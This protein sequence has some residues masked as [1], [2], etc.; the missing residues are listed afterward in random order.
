MRMSRETNEI[1]R[2]R[3]LL[4]SL[5]GRAVKFARFLSLVIGLTAMATSLLT[6][7]SAAVRS[8][9][10][11]REGQAVVTR[12]TSFD[13]LAGSD[14]QYHEGAVAHGEQAAPDSVAWK[15]VT[16]PF[17]A[18]N[19]EVWIRRWV[20][21]PKSLNGYDLTGA[22]ISFYL[23]VGGD[24]PG[25]GYLYE[26][27]YGSG[28]LIAEGTH[29]Y[30]QVI[31]ADAHP[32][33][34]VLLAVKMP[35][36]LGE[37]RFDRVR[38]QVDFAEGRPDPDVMR[39]ELVSAATLLPLI[40]HDAAE[41]ASQEKTLDSAAR[42][43]NLDALDKG[44]QKAFDASLKDA[45]ARLEPLRPVMKKSFV[46]MTGNAHIDAAWLWS[47]T[48]T[49]DQVH[50]TFNNV[51]Q[52]MREYPQYAFS[53]SAAQY[54]EWMEQKFPFI[55]Q[56]IQQRVKEGRWELVGGMWV[57]PDLNLPDG[58]GEV[59]QILVGKQ[60]FQQK[61]GVDVK[62]GWNPDSFGYNWQ[63]PQIYKKSGIDYFL[64]QKLN[65]NDDNILPLKLFWWQSPDGSR[66]LTYFPHDY[67]QNIE[68][69]KMAHDLAAV[70]KANP[71]DDK[72]L[73]LYGGSLGRQGIPEGRDVQEAGILWS[74]PD[75]VYPDTRFT[76]AQAFFDDMA[77]RADTATTTVWNYKTL[78]AG[79][80]QVA[81]GADG[82]IHLPVWNDE[83]YLEHHR[84][85]YTTQAQEKANIRHS[86]EWL[87]DAEKYS[88]LAW[89][90][91]LDYPGNQ[92]TESWKRKSFNDFHDT[93]AGSGIAVV[94]R[95]AEKEYDEIHRV[96]G[97]ATRNALKEVDS[98]INT[99]AH[100]GVPIVVWNQLNWA[101]TETIP[102][103][104]QMPEPE[105]NGIA[106]V[107]A[108][109]K[110]VPMQV[111]SKDAATNSYKLLL[112]VHDVP[113][114]GYTVLY[115]IAGERKVTSDLQLH[116]TTMENSQLRVV[117]DPK[118]G[119]ITSLYQKR[120]GV[121]SI[122]SGQCGNMLQ[123]FVDNSVVEDAWN[124]DKDF[125]KYTTN[126]T[127][128]DSMKVVEQGPLRE[129]I[130]ITRSW[131]KSKFVQDIVLEAGSPRVD[132][133]NEVDWHE[134]HVMLKA[135]FPLAHSSDAATYE[136]PF[137][138]IERPTT[139]NNS[140]EDSK[141]EVPALRW[142][143]LGDGKNGFSLINEAKYGYDAKG[144]MLRLTLLR[145]P[146]YPDPDA[147][148]GH[149][150]FTYTLYPHAG[151]WKTA[152]TVLRGYEYNYKMYAGQTM[153]HAGELPTSHSFVSIKPDNLVMTAMKRSEDGDG[154]ILRFYEWA[155]KQTQAQI[156]LP[157][158]ATHAVETNLMEK[159]GEGA[160]ATLPVS[161]NKVELQVGPYSI[162]TVRVGF[163][164][165]S[166]GFWPAQK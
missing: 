95:D 156:T 153:A 161:N 67:V 97:D 66:V 73:H 49:V 135:A 138:S 148:R 62:V 133:E 102:V 96:A 69:V 2:Q 134:T 137:G 83:L 119:C 50:F 142:A 149:Q 122:A 101:R 70:M 56:Q 4:C 126:L 109:G 24:G 151:T 45:Q 132:V 25:H 3:I 71:G 139:R 1:L 124:I 150:H 64:T 17:V 87:L 159:N 131:S 123:A 107:D 160:N 163:G 140:V 53:Q 143:D 157:A 42:A 37:K 60:Y 54:Y 108:G 116:G 164:A 72:L 58:E 27:I 59:R 117:L 110:T 6:A 92:F 103:S 94:Y 40:T 23:E 9:Q 12:L 155:G 52:L 145:S 10:F 16:I 100:A 82:K 98:H 118:T 81:G 14:W 99:S 39:T 76:T 89:L 141:F 5:A 111:V 74:D 112:Q 84:G 129:T 8:Y 13:S 152:D 31:I 136:I 57:E 22:H 61:F 11:S 43:V 26:T 166:E 88:A 34:K 104:V 51:L 165:R 77:K 20:E 46:T 32:G 65:Y 106:V 90:G 41:L 113:S 47:W 29:L 147:D 19:Q 15:D 91:G 121:E 30:K 130:R 86:E 125:E 115:A 114:M 36:T 63:L 85:I 35:P 80:T 79:E 146:V 93:A 78:G 18:S 128:L 33:D 75:K 21:I 120:T 158:G 28:K 48:E 44:D 162:N 144:N 105:P 38:F 7:Q 68:P 154:L 127:M 55:F